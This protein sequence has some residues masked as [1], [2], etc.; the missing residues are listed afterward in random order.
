MSKYNFE[1]FGV[2]NKYFTEVITTFEEE[3][4]PH[5]VADKMARL[6]V[7]KLLV[8][9]NVSHP[10]KLPFVPNNQTEDNVTYYFG[11]KNLPRPRQGW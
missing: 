6:E 7:C 10:D 4:E 5:V 1:V 9:Y 8:E 11:D 2:E 3:E